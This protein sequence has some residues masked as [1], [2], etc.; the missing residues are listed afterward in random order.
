VRLSLR[1]IAPSPSPITE[2][3]WPDEKGGTTVPPPRLLFLKEQPGKLGDLHN[4][5]IIVSYKE[6]AGKSAKE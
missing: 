3:S 6:A 4:F 2:A 5:S 1:K